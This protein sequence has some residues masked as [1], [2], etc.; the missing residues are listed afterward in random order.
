V[1]TLSNM[2][3]LSVFEILLV[4][5]SCDNGGNVNDGGMLVMVVIIVMV[6]NMV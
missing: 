4:V 2:Y 5:G 6:V 1:D 3:I